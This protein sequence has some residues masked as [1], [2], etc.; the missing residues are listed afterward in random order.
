MNNKPNIGV[1]GCGWLGLPLGNYLY[2]KGHK[3]FGSTTSTHKLDTLKAN[4]I[5]PG[6]LKLNK[7]GPEGDLSLFDKCEILII[8]IPPLRS[9]PEVVFYEE[10]ILRLLDQLEESKLKHILF[11]SST[12]VY[13]QEEK[14]LTENTRPKPISESGKQLLNVEDVLINHIKWQNT[15]I[16][17]GGLIGYNRM[18]GRFLA[19]KKNLKKGGSPVNLIHQD[20]CI[21]AIYQIINQK[22]WGS[23]Y[24]A[25]APE[26]PSKMDFYTKAAHSIGINAPY[27]QDLDDSG[28]SIS[29]E[30]LIKDL[31]FKFKY[32]NPLN[33]IF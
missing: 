17:F 7:T 11:V 3:V 20:D 1:L 19:K 32:I 6:I 9:S 24:N 14:L 25:C 8:N 2:N 18:P 21:E 16:R 31:R 23:T 12:S 33:C 30:L 4:H 13:G 22:K 28:K 5:Q 26:H 15:I 27:F 10:K 29:S